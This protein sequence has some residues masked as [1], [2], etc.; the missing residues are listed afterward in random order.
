MSQTN[1]GSSILDQESQ[2]GDAVDQP[3]IGY[4][5][6]QDEIDE[7]LYGETGST[8]DRLSKLRELR[9]QITARGQAEWMGDDPQ[10]MLGE[11]ETS[12]QRLEG[13][14]QNDEDTDYTIDDTM[15]DVDPLAHRETLSPDDD[16]LLDAMDA[17]AASLEDDEDGEDEGDEVLDESEW[18]GE[19][20]GFD[21]E[22][23]VS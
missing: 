3:G 7:L 16:E 2:L 1:S 11:I 9:D 15:M 21:P 10:R 12:I 17:E 22:R 14:S 4:P 18:T 8:G 20:D 5:F 6:T 13:V 19:G 23:G